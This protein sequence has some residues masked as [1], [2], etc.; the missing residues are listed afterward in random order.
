MPI[1]SILQVLLLVIA[2][3]L[4]GLDIASNAELIPGLKPWIWQWIGF[5]A[6]VG[7]MGWRIVQQAMRI[8]PKLE[9][10]LVNGA[11]LEGPLIEADV[12]L[13]RHRPTPTWGF[14]TNPRPWRAWARIHVIFTNH[15]ETSAVPI[16]QA[17][18]MIR[19]RPAWVDHLPLAD[20]F[21]WFPKKA[22]RLEMHWFLSKISHK[23]IGGTSSLVIPIGPE[24]S[25]DRSP[26][27]FRVPPLSQSDPYPLE[28]ETELPRGRLPSHLQFVLVLQLIGP[29]LEQSYVLADVQI[30][31]PLKKQW[32]LGRK[33]RVF[34]RRSAH[35]L[36]HRR[37]HRCGS[38]RPLNRQSNSSGYASSTRTD[39]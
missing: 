16:R 17:T 34:H 20:K 28:G 29:Q 26:V 24:Q 13:H 33:F 31:S 7:A 25:P 8:D 14:S 5:V 9:V 18:L 38:R 19:A 1:P 15:H 4:F 21:G 37:R 36:L 12:A 22:L 27:S 30:P 6:A 11:S 39:P 2:A 35:Q 10:R 23:P 32:R 3:G